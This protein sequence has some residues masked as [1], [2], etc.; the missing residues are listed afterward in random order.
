MGDPG[1]SIDNSDGRTIRFHL[2]GIF[3]PKFSEPDVCKAGQGISAWSTDAGA[4]FCSFP[5]FIK[6]SSRDRKNM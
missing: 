5:R 6:F 3:K 2:K 1:V 4:M